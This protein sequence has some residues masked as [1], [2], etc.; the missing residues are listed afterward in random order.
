MGDDDY[1]DVGD[2]IGYKG[3]QIVHI[4]ARSLYHKVDALRNDIFGK[5]IGI[6]GITETWLKPSV[7]CSLVSVKGFCLLRNDRVRGRGGGY[8]PIYT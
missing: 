8:L 7:P 4:N 3:L 5:H 1:I 6:L 2:L